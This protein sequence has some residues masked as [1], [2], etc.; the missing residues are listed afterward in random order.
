MFGPDFLLRLC[1]R[2]PAL[3]LALTVHEWAHAFVAMRKRD[4][5]AYHAGR[6]S[7]NPLVHLDPVGTIGLVLGFIGW[8]RPVP[9]EI[10][11]LRNPLKDLFWISFAGPGSNL[12]M[13]FVFGTVLRVWHL[14]APPTIPMANRVVWFFYTFVVMALVY[15]LFLACFN[16]IPLKPLDG[17][18]VLRGLLPRNKIAGFEQFQ[19]YGPFILLGLIVWGFRS[20]FNVLFIVIRFLANPVSWLVSGLNLDQNLFQLEM[21]FQIFR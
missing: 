19:Q 20:D 13:A 14:A 8:G 18:S 21:L 16:L 5:T 1:V 4:L 12:A 3:L 17:A 6:V 2:L 7:F 10:R 9:V 15:N 11:N